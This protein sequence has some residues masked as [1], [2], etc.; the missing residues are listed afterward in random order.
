[1]W[2]PLEANDYVGIQVSLRR[3]YKTKGYQKKILALQNYFLILSFS[4][5]TAGTPPVSSSLYADSGRTTSQSFPDLL[6]VPGSLVMLS[7]YK[8]SILA[9]TYLTRQPLGLASANICNGSRYFVDGR[10]WNGYENQRSM[11][12]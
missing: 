6:L 10:I 2:H 5:G 9:H 11:G 4:G 8:R 12:C 3:R 7:P 1:M